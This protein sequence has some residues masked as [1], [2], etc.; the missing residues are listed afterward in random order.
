MKVGD[1]VRTKYGI[2]KVIQIDNE[3]TSKIICYVVDKFY[4]E[5]KICSSNYIYDEDIIKQS[6]N[7][8][9]LIEV[10]D[11]VNGS[12]VCKIYDNKHLDN[13]IKEVICMGKD[14]FEGELIYTNDDINSIVTYEQFESMK[15]KVG[16]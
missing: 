7:I 14:G 16:E 6:P 12:E 10:G 15:Y 2:R 5:C 13:P 4:N 8:I 3:T 1:Y 11:Y 9:D